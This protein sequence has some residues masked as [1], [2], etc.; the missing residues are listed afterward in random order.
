MRREVRGGWRASEVESPSPSSTTGC[1]SSA[2]GLHARGDLL[3]LAEARADDEG[4]RS[5]GRRGRRRGSDRRRA[6]RDRPASVGPRIVDHA[7][8][9]GRI[10]GAS[11]CAAVHCEVGG[12]GHLGATRRCT[13]RPLPL[14]GVGQA[15]RA[16]RRPRPDAL[17]LV[18][19]NRGHVQPD[20]GS[21][22]VPARTIVERRAG[23]GGERSRCAPP[24]GP[25]AGRHA[26]E[27]VH[28]GGDV[29]GEHRGVTGVRRLVGTAEAGAV[30]ASMTKVGG[31]Q[32]RQEVGRDPAPGRPAPLE[33]R[34]RRRARRCRCCPCRRRRH[35]AASV[36]PAERS[37]AACATAAPGPPGSGRRPARGRRRR[38]PHLS[39]VTTGSPA[40]PPSQ[41][42]RDGVGGRVAGSG[43]AA[44]ARRR[45]PRPS[46]QARPC[47]ATAGAP[48]S[49]RRG[50]PRC[51]VNS[52][53]PRLH[54]QRLHHRL[55]GCVS[56]RRSA[57][58]VVAP[59]PA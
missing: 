44:N 1:D 7:R 49:C 50:R 28:A 47:S 18:D 9:L 4:A 14:V 29:V 54:A 45:P 33:A 2:A 21:V 30:A 27:A 56:G 25:E 26:G 51:R 13:H 36:G 40:P 5:G 46:R 55:L 59:L 34:R 48:E 15:G 12:A 10:A 31:R 53:A 24:A 23:E 6:G 20:V 3:A 39:G 37:I 22:Y 42:H 58:S 16:A 11:A 19:R 41:R 17:D 8:R 52:Q 32:R 43:S 57:R 38:W 35:G